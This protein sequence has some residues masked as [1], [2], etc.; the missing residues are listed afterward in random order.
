MEKS[1]KNLSI[2]NKIILII[3]FCFT[4][5][6]AL[7]YFFSTN[8]LLERFVDLEKDQVVRNLDRVDFFLKSNS[9]NQSTKIKDWA[10]WDDTY[11]FINDKN[12]E[13]IESNLGDETLV[14]INLNAIVFIDNNNEIIFSKFLDLE[15][16]TNL[17]DENFIS[18]INTNIN[19]IKK[20]KEKKDG[21]NIIKLIEGD[22][23]ISSEDI[24]KSDGTGTSRGTIIFGTFLNNSLIKNISEFTRFHTNIYPYINSEKIQDLFIAKN[25]LSISNKY[26]VEASSNDFVYGYSLIYD[27]YDK[28]I[29]IIKVE[30]PRDIYNQGKSTVTS[31]F[32]IIISFLFI[33]G[34]L[35]IYLIK[36]FILNRLIVL[37]D[38]VNKISDN[39]DFEKLDIKDDHY[40]EIGSIA[41]VI[42]KMLLKIKIIDEKERAFI[43]SENLINKKRKVE[44][45]EIE[46]LN[47]LMIGR[48]LKMIE[49]KKE[50]SRLKEGVK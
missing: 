1:K 4:F 42:N 33:I 40:D 8:F 30:I 50:N 3:L 45:D 12:T 47:K 28:P 9:I 32:L 15:S 27:I 7:I 31:F 16:K 49:L 37:E 46:K 43:K 44:M 20:L 34:I 11:K 38:K 10:F 19:D 6:S 23:I 14:S 35:I 26:F 2:K 39:N 17:P 48:E 13:Y 22:M 18:Y 36:L 21:F 41:S 29:D 25:N 24:L 5:F